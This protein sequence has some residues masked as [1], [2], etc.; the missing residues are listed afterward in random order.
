MNARMLR[1]LSAFA[2][3]ALLA[4]LA[5]ASEVST[6]DAARAAK[7]WV[8]R[9][10]AM[11]KLP[12][13]RTV[14][15]VDEVE[16]PATGARLLV[17]KFEGGGFVV[18]SADDLVDPVLAFSE[19]GDG[20]DRDE[21]NPFWALLRGDIAAREAA[22]GVVRGA[23]PVPA[24][25]SP[26]AAP[27]APTAAQ[28]KWA[29]L[30]GAED[31]TD[32]NGARRHEETAASGVET[33]S[34][35]RVDSFVESRWNQKTYSNYS[36][37]KNCYNY[38]TPNNYYC[39]CVATA[40][41][42]IMRYWQ[43]PRTAVTANSY[44]CAVDGSAVTK[45]MMGGVYDWSKMPLK[46]Y[47]SVPS[48]EECQAIGKLIYDVG[49]TVEMNWKSSGSSA[50]IY[51]GVACLPIDFGYANAKAAQYDYGSSWDLAHFKKCVIPNMDA[52]CPVGL[53]IK[54]SVHNY[55]HAVLADGYG[56]SGNDWYIHVNFGWG[57]RYS[58]YDAWYCP[59][60]L[61]TTNGEYDTIHGCLF[62]VF[63]EKT[64]SIASGRIL[65]TTGSPVSG[66]T[67]SLSDGQTATSD[68][69][70]IYAF[71]ASAGTYTI[72][73]AKGSATASR[74]VTLGNTTG[75]TII[76]SSGSRGNYY[77]GT[78]SMGNLYDQDITLAV[79]KDTAP[80]IS[81]AT[82]TDVSFT[83]AKI[84][85]A[86]SDLGMGSSYADVSAT[87]GGSTKTGRVNAAGGSATLSFTGLS[88]G[89]QHTAT[90]TA[91]GSNGLSATRTVTFTTSAYGPPTIGT[92][93]VSDVTQTG[94]KVSVPVTSLGAGSSSVT[95][96]IVVDGVERTATVSA[97]GGV[98]TAV[99]SGLGAETS[100][101]AAITATGS[102]GKSATASKA[103]T[104]AS[105]V[106][107]GWFDV[108]WTTQGWG[109]GAGWLTAAGQSAAGG[110]FAVPAG[111][112]SSLSGGLLA[113][114][115]PEGGQLRFTACEPSAAGGT[116]KVEGRLVPG[117]SR[118]PPEPPAGAIAGLSFTSSGYRGWNGSQWVSLSGATP[119]DS[120]TDWVAA[121][122]FT[123]SPAKVRYSVGGTVL[124][125]NGSAWIPLA[126]AHTYVEGVGY[127][128]GGSVGDFKATKSGGFDVPVLASPALDG[129]EP[130]ELTG[131]K[132]TL[133][134]DNAVSGAYYTVYA[135][136][137]VSG[138]YRAVK[139][140]RASASGIFPLPDIDTASDSRFFR[141]GVSDAAVPA[142]TVA[143]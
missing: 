102:N 74:S 115:L 27:A 19:T 108:R 127:A 1:P 83:S 124:A 121:F 36:G 141:V 50:S 7:A 16:D 51:S 128:G 116:V 14:S 54:D 118:N 71:I 6:D 38:Y 8:D 31:A 98:A 123:G 25:G 13:G 77:S 59:P 105:L 86:V 138:P 91:T 75:T 48:D 97:A 23:D 67:V 33:I 60:D 64:G 114:A 78:G 130:M 110:R 101:T 126:T 79:S 18:L 40:I 41:G 42:Q 99:F 73:A 21:N 68:A 85:V 22:A 9:G 96:T 2:L 45:T 117:R 55:G 89:T 35:I 57:S 143:P 90:V 15:A 10:Y 53:S 17:A 37:D 93:S 133:R 76:T 26:Q 137:S 11:G 104:T 119:S 113:L 65:D 32:E 134:I 61:K 30:L 111:D 66:A 72:T 12:V 80:T 95:V 4:E 100:Y 112:A 103:F 139:S 34:D 5:P 94:A 120:A 43:Y 107:T 56:Y 142:N 3:L 62:N 69:N 82:A 63:P 87:V 92:V 39:G 125:A 84:V 122:D 20:I 46:P 28:R 88:D 129:V 47:L 44:P 70:G 136:D 109:S 24:A 29:A 140:I 52:R 131:S 106:F 49:V 135:S 58:A 81:S 132:L